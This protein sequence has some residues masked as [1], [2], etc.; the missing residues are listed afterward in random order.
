[1]CMVY[2][3]LRHTMGPGHEAFDVY[4]FSFDQIIK[5]KGQVMPLGWGGVV[6]GLTDRRTD[7]QPGP[8]RT[9]YRQL[10]ML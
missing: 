2:N 5:A 10:C 4:G 8:P 6:G 7:I 1:M 9:L 3:S